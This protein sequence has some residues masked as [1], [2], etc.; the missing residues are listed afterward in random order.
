MYLKKSI[1]IHPKGCNKSQAKKWILDKLGEDT[2]I[3]FYGDKTLKG[4]NDYEIAMMCGKYFDIEAP[5]DTIIL[6]EQ[7][8]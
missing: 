8:S 5:E 6:L 1:D 4:G 7:F 2:T 3:Y